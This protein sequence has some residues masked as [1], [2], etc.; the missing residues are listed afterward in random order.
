MSSLGIAPVFLS[1]LLLG[2]WAD[3]ANWSMRHRNLLAAP[4]SSSIKC[5]LNF[6]VLNKFSDAA[7]RAQRG[8]L[9][10]RCKSVLQG[11]QLVLAEYLRTNGLFLPPQNASEACWDAYQNEVIQAGTSFDMRSSCGFETPWISQGCM[12]ITTLQQFESI[13]PLNGRQN[14]EKA[15][16]QSLGTSSPCA[17]CTS[18]LSSIQAL[19]LLGPSEGNVTDCLAYANIYAAAIANAFGPTDTGTAW[20]LFLVSLQS[21]PGK[22][23]AWAFA[24]AAAVVSVVI[25]V[26]VLGFLY[27]RKRA[28]EK[29]KALAEKLQATASEPSSMNPNSTLVRFTIEEIRAATG[30]FSRHNIVGTGGFGNVYKGFLA[31][32]SVVAVKRFKNCS[33]A[34]DPGFVHEVEVISSIRHRNLVALRGF[35]MAPASL[36]GHQRII[37]CEYMPNGSLHDHL[38]GQNP[39]T[40]LDWPTRQKIAV[41]MARGLAY[42]H[43]DAQPAIIHRDIKASNILLDENFDAR[44]AD[45]GLA[46][47]TPE[48][49]THLSTRVAGTL[50]YVAPEYA[51][52]GQL[53]Q[54]SDVYSFGVVLLELLSGRKALNTISQSQSAHITDWAWSL[55]KMGRSLEVIEDGLENQG[56]HEVME[57]Y[58]LVALLCA[59]PQLFCRPSIDQV[60][61]IMDCD[62]PVPPIPDRPIP[63]VSDLEDIERSFSGSG[64]GQLSS[65]SGYQSFSTEKNPS[66]FQSYN[67][68]KS[69][70]ESPGIQ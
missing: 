52:Y 19:Y 15:C 64:S 53:T 32:G 45:F 24:V 7:Q 69:T 17:Q 60:L 16:N 22:N 9:N 3:E 58:V 50:G 38:F 5:P 8:D 66:G 2:C 56:P 43:R 55:V 29:K 62:L 59:H 14:I 6:S 21:K 39:Q 36:E 18:S 54:K 37:V 41:G 40:R 49:M 47:F 27:L 57:R 34:G 67:K 68:E 65:P 10:L 35:C 61:K 28:A 12:N 42:L 25:L 30:N 46:K 51:L 13:V 63:L 44:V 26:A 11:L 33:P 70:S 31:D 1:L 48:G 4:P 20:C 23:K